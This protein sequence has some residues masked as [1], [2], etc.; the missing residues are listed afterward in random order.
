MSVALSIQ[1]IANQFS[2]LDSQDPVTVPY[3]EPY[4]CST[5]YRISFLGCQF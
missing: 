4:K 3:L 5:Y 2:S 1:K